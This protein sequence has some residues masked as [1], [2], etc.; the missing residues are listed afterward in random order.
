MKKQVVYLSL[1]I[2]LFL[3]FIPNLSK[4]A[5][6]NLADFNQ[7][8]GEEEN[9]GAGSALSEIGDINADGYDDF[10]IGAPSH[11]VSG[12]GANSGIAYLIYGQADSYLS[13]NNMFDISIEF[14]GV[15][16]GDMAGGQVAGAGDVNADGYDDFLIAAAAKDS[17]N[18]R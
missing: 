13:V 10:M 14:R 12:V 18:L 15:N 5:D 1:I 7:F 8:I 16:A 4:A 17:S 3:V 6:M 11:N 9:D 2:G